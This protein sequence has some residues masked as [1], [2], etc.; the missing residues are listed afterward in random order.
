M[1]LLERCCRLLK[2]HT[3][4]LHCTFLF[5]LTFDSVRLTMKAILSVIVSC[6]CCRPIAQVRREHPF[7]SSFSMT[8]VAL[9]PCTSSHSMLTSVSSI[10]PLIS[11]RGAPSLMNV[12][13]TSMT[14]TPM[15][16]TG[17]HIYCALFHIIFIQ[18]FT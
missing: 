12:Y 2:W 11:H 14:I 7:C 1:T 10:C 8:W 18:L 15:L 3:I 9:T 17:S 16:C 4:H 6:V 13:R 5:Y